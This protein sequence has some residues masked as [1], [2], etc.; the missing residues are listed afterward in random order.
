MNT[1]EITFSADTIPA[2]KKDTANR[3][4][5]PTDS[6]TINKGGIETTIK[7]YAED[8]IITQTLTNVTYLYGNAYI[9][10]GDIKL[11]AA[12]IIINRNTNELTA[13][14]VQ[15]STNTWIGLPIF[16]DGPEKFETREIRYNFD[17]NKARIK[18]VATQ[19]QEG[20]LSGE[21]VKRQDDG[22]AYIAGG[23]YIPC[24]DPQGT[25][26]IKSTKIKI[27]PGDKVITGPFNLYVGGIPTPLWL[28]FGI[29]PEPKS[30]EKS[31]ILFPKYGNEQNRGLFLR[32]GGYF[33]VW[34]RNL[35]TA[36][37]ADI[38]SKGSWGLKATNQYRKRYAYSGRFDFTFNRNRNLEF[39]ENRLDSRDFWFAWSHQPESRGTGRFSASVNV[40]TSTFNANNVA[41][42]NFQQN[43]RS[44]FRSNVSYSNSIAGTPFSYSFNARHNQ[45]VQTGIVDISLP[46][47]SANMNRI[48]PLKGSRSEVL[49]K[50][51]IG[52][53]FNVTNRI[54]NLVRPA[55]TGFT[56]ANQEVTQDTIDVR[57]NTIN[58]LLDNA[59]NGARHSIPISTSFPVLKNFNLTPSVQFQE[60]WY[61]EEL[62]YTFIEDQ[63]AVQID[64]VG[65]F[66]RASTYSASLGLSTQLYGMF[67][68]KRWR[69]VEAIRHI[70]TPTVSFNYR[71]DFSDERF[72]Y[73]QTVQT[74]TTGTT[75]L[76]SIYDGFAFG[77]SWP[78]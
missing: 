53:N 26:Y 50:L 27:I 64:T 38:Y 77:A 66:S 43:I 39:E 9:E 49:K 75:R 47:F 65:G 29:F 54:T 46:E 15:D 33:F 57:F 63:N 10:Y 55:S 5:A 61:L 59:V 19:Q 45:N 14:G 73:Y 3:R 21:V 2:V 69:N 20:Y 44:E 12:E 62:D 28:P 67:N 68:T 4:P 56:I 7:Y 58:E 70:M 30:A 16:Q 6:I 42:N 1:S 71:P 24:D 41:V 37:T 34:N 22:S 40:G 31:G 8:S 72:G 25:T 51:N 60:L 74:D 76:L 78:G 32:E 23:R 48:F 35:H 52:W 13:R 11:D 18:G 36:L 17:T